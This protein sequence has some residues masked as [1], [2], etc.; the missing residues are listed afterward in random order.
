MDG[1]NGEEEERYLKLLETL[2]K[3]RTDQLQE[4]VRQNEQLLEVL[5]QIQSMESL[6]Q[7]REATHAAIRKFTPE[8]TAER[9]QPRMFGGKAGE[10]CQNPP[11]DGNEFLRLCDEVTK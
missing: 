8:Q 5:K 2:V 4:V 9:T 11:F 3:A 7:V 6:E 10:P 1:M